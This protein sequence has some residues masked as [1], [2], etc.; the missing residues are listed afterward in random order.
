MYLLTLFTLPLQL[1]ELKN[2]DNW[3]V[4]RLFNAS[5][6]L[7]FDC[8]T[9]K[10]AQSNNRYTWHSY[11]EAFEAYI[12][13]SYDGLGFMLSDGYVGIDLDNCISNSI[14]VNDIAKDILD[15]V[16]SYTEYSPSKTGL[17]I[18]CKSDSN[19]KIGR[20]NDKLGIE[21]YNHNR[22][23]TITGD[24]YKDMPIEYRDVKIV[25]SKYFNDMSSILDEYLYMEV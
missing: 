3:V 13:H 21:I 24:V 4:Y 5:S 25:I 22:F 23:F 11:D 8:I 19:L 1:Y 9:H 7:P 2:Y 15:M 12:N 18:L 20:K 17:H 6:K 14:I 10:P 16:D